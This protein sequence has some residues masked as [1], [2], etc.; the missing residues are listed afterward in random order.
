[1][2]ANQILVLSGLLGIAGQDCMNVFPEH[3]VEDAIILAAIVDGNAKVVKA[4]I[5]FGHRPADITIERL[6]MARQKGDAFGREMANLFANAVAGASWRPTAAPLS[7]A[8]H[9]LLQTA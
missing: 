4:A 7:I 5:L 6:A 9:H 2:K 8:E 1:M 3:S